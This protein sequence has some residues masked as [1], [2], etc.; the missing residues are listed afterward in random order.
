[1]A[2]SRTRSG[3]SSPSSLEAAEAAGCAALPER[4]PGDVVL[5]VERCGGAGRPL[6]LAAGLKAGLPAP[7]LKP[8]APKS[9]WGVGS[10]GA[11]CAATAAGV[12]APNGC[13]DG[14]NTLLGVTKGAEPAGL[15]K[16]KVGVPTDG[17]ARAKDEAEEEEEAMLTSPRSDPLRL[18]ADPSGVAWARCWGSGAAAA[19]CCGAAAGGC[20]RYSCCCARVSATAEGATVAVAC[21]EGWAAW[22]ARGRAGAESAPGEKT[23]GALNAPGGPLLLA[24]LG[25][26]SSDTASED[27]P[28]GARLLPEARRAG[29]VCTGVTDRLTAAAGCGKNIGVCATNG[30]SKV[31]VAGVPAAA[32]GVGVPIRM[33]SLPG[34]GMNEAAAAGAN[35]APGV[36]VKPD[37]KPLEEAGVDALHTPAAPSRTPAPGAA[38]AGSDCG[39]CSALATDAAADGLAC[40]VDGFGVTDEV[41]VVLLLRPLF[42]LTGLPVDVAPTENE[43]SGD[44]LVNGGSISACVSGRHPARRQDR[45]SLEIDKFSVGVQEKQNQRSESVS[46]G[47]RTA[48]PLDA[49]RETMALWP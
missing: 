22:P 14:G 11:C 44:I 33:K 12:A 42:G 18:Q 34:V 38:A 39:C 24:T 45:R 20:G 49:R 36:K 10:S 41:A 9:T 1:M 40:L 3:A 2:S 6:L 19:G 25:C 15:P 21:A 4:E 46:A 30:N 31:G 17:L 26:G 13:A 28:P 48:W 5:G 35:P 8:P 16:E 43:R 27:G 7:G 32:L 47:V 23:K 37:E 29:V